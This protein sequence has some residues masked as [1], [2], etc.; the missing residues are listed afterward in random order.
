MWGNT[1]KG[2]IYI[3]SSYK[4]INRP[5]QNTPL[6]ERCGRGNGGAGRDKKGEEDWK[7]EMVK[8]GGGRRVK[9]GRGI[10]GFLFLLA[11]S[12]A[13]ENGKRVSSDTTGKSTAFG[14]AIW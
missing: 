1:Q 10:V 13:K 2:L 8:E 4:P 9:G 7:E 6:K 5:V 14:R 12:T 11:S 3:K